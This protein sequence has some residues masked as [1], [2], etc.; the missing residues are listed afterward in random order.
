MKVKNALK[1]SPNKLVFWV[2]CVLTHS[3]EARACR[4]TNDQRSLTHLD[5]IY[6]GYSQFLFLASWLSPA[7]GPQVLTSPLR[8]ADSWL[9]SE[10]GCTMGRAVGFIAMSC[11]DPEDVS[12][13][14]AAALPELSK[15][16]A[17]SSSSLT[18]TEIQ[19]NTSILWL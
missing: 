9:L 15:R 12:K 8:T 5:R 17:P 11:T 1:T 3:A 18:G 4:G 7:L 14:S 2:T 13:G 16:T 10:V 19:T 6:P